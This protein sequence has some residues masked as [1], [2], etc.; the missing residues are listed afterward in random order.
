MK[1]CHFFIFF[2]CE[3]HLNVKLATHYII[4]VFIVIYIH[5]NSFDLV[6]MWQNYLTGKLQKN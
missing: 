2:V 4:K 3:I 5:K 1:N 6:S